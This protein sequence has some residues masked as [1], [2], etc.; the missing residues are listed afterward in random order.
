MPKMTKRER[1]QQIADEILE[2]FENG[3]VPKALAR[4][5]ICRG[6]DGPSEAWSWRNRLLVALRGHYDARGFRQWKQ[7]GRSVKKGSKAIYILGP[8]KAKVTVEEE[9]EDGEEK[10]EERVVGF[11]PIPVFGYQQTEGEPLAGEEEAAEFIDALPLVE[12]ARAWEL[13]VITYAAP[14][15]PKLGFYRGGQLIALGVENISVWAHELIHAADHRL[16]TLTHGPGQR[17]DNEV[18]A[19]LG[20]TVLLECLGCETESDRGG[21]FEYLK[22]YAEQHGRELLSVCTEFLERTCKCV[23]FLLDTAEELATSLE[24]NELE[25]NEE[26][27]NAA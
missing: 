19:E 6:T 15:S 8:C 20:G 14:G 27:A 26:E 12:V 11:T 22:T 23:A 10:L 18:V 4:I 13:D 25:D 9:A 3:S 21:A 5:F 17:L 1:A 24:D 16:G 2:A 7:V